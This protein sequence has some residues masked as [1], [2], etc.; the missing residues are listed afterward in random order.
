MKYIRKFLEN[1][2]YSDRELMIQEFEE[3]FHFPLHHLTDRLIEWEDKGL[4][5]ILEAAVWIKS[6]LCV[7]T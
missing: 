4:N 3:V 5:L 6:E 2:E 7:M 1:V